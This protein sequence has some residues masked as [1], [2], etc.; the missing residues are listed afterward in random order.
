VSILHTPQYPLRVCM[1]LAR[2]GD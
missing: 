1:L 2:I